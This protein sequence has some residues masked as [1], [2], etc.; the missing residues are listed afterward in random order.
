MK[1]LP[2]AMELLRLAGVVLVAGML[3][4]VVMPAEVGR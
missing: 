3:L 1:Y 4:A 2:Y